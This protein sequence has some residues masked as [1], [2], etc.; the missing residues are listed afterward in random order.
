MKNEF[1]A[2]GA[3]RLWL[4]QR[5]LSMESLHQKYAKELAQA[6]PAQKREILDRMLEDFYRQ[7]NHKPS[8]GTLW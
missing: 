2:D 5:K 4:G 7:K 6:A 8:A 3:G 1:V